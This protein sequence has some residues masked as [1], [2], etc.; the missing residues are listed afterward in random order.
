M[1]THN[2]FF[3]DNVYKLNNYIFISTHYAFLLRKY[4]ILKYEIQVLQPI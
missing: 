1:V 4:T 2:I 3:F